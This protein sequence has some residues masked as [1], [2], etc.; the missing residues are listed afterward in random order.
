VKVERD[1]SR[2][3]Y[4]FS[5]QGHKNQNSIFCMSAD[6]FQIFGCL[7]VIK[8]KIK[9]LLASMKAITN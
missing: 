3:D 1:S 7:F 9:F 5:S 2:D 6:G 8:S 4:F